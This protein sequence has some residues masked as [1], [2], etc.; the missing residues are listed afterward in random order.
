MEALGL[1]VL[2]IQLPQDAQTELI[3]FQG[4]LHLAFLDLRAADV[5]ETRGLV[6]KITAA[7]ADSVRLLKD[8]DSHVEVELL[9]VAGAHVEQALALAHGVLALA[10]DLEALGKVRQ[11]TILISCLA[12]ADGKVVEA[13]RNAHCVAQ[14]PADLERCSVL[15]QPLVRPPLRGEQLAHGRHAVRQAVHVLTFLAHFYALLVSLA[16]RRQ[17]VEEAVDGA[18]L[19]Q[20]LGLPAPVAHDPP[21]LQTLLHFIQRRIKLLQLNMALGHLHQYARL[22]RTIPFLPPQPQR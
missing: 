7:A 10:H 3:L 2:V 19:V 21:E 13:F 14:L 8:L 11:R 5:A 20:A 22:A 18:E 15:V 6:L 12:E 16:R 17:V 4:I 9:R 1:P